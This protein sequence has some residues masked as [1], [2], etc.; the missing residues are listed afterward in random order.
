MARYARAAGASVPEVVRGIVARN[1]SVYDCMRMDLINYTAL[2]ARLRPEVERQLG[3]PVNLN[4]IVVAIKRYADSFGPEEEAGG[5]PVLK[6]ARISL[7]DGMVDIRISAGGA[8]PADLLERFSRVTK[9]YDFFM[10]P[11]SFRLLAEDLEG[12]RSIVRDLPRA[13]AAPRAGL[14]RMRISIPGGGRAGAGSYVAE[15]LHKNG[16]EFVDAYLGRD[17]MTM[18]LDRDDAP[19]AYDILRTEV[20]G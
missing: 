13:S 19:R 7:T 14:V 11:G 4:T 12:V 15:L 9:D 3:A 20:A 18:T 16:I 5:E 17:S 10:L 8:R 2:A 1:R 6:D